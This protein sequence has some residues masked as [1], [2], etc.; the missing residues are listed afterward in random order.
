MRNPVALKS[1]THTCNIL[2]LQCDSTSKMST[3]Y[4]FVDRCGCCRSPLIEKKSAKKK[5]PRYMCLK[6]LYMCPHATICVSSS[7]LYV[8]SSHYIC[9]LMRLNTQEDSTWPHKNTHTHIQTH[10]HRQHTHKQ[11]DYAIVRASMLLQI[12]THSHTPPGC[13]VKWGAEEFWK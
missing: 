4:E 2:F 6:P 5:M 7:P 10:T 12:R 1:M 11:A 13:K 3:K 8:S 9:V